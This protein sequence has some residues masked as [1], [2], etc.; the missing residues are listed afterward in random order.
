MDGRHHFIIEKLAN[1]IG[2]DKNAI[3]EYLIIDP[4][5]SWNDWFD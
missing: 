3:E 1:A 4:K 5:V 2:V